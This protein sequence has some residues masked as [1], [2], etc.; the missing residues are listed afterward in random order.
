MSDMQ[1]AVQQ[2]PS[3][4]E[5]VSICYN[6]SPHSIQQGEVCEASKGTRGADWDLFVFNEVTITYWGIRIT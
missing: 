1:N 2:R 5:S 6:I 3:I 4:S